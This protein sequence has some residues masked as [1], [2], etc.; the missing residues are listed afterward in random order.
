MKYKILN[1]TDNRIELS[2]LYDDNT[3]TTLNMVNTNDK[4]SVLKD[5]YIIS[6]DAR[7]R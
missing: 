3:F 2:V 6:N 4:E 7:N 5:V 1:Q